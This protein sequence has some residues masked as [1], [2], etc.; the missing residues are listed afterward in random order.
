M[1]KTLATER[2]QRLIALIIEAREKV[3]MTQTD[4]ADALGEY[5]SFV[6]RLESG[7]RR[8]D[9]IEFIRLAEIL[10]FDA[11]KLMAKVRKIAI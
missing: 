5:Q 1:D 9:V 11:P 10:D 2:H 4:L 3:G 7:Q 6:A 8:L